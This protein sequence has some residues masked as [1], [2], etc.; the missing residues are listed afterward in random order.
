MATQLRTGFT[1]HTSA[2][3]RAIINSL[4]VESIQVAGF[5][6]KY[7]PRTSN[8]IDT[9]FEDAET[10]SFDDAY[11]IEM[12]FGANSLTGFGGDGDLI[13]QFGYEVRDTVQLVVS[14]SRFVSEIGTPASLERPREGDLIHL[15]F[16][17]QL[18]EI[19]FVEDQEPFF[20]LGY[21]YIYQLECSLFQYADEE[22][23]TGDVT[24]DS[25]ETALAYQINLT[26]NP[27]TGIFTVGTTVYQGEVGSET[28]KAEVVLWS[29]GTNTLRVMN[30]Q[31]AFKTTEVVKYDGSNYGTVTAIADQDTVT[32]QSAEFETLADSGIV[33]FTESNPFGDF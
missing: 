18:Y 27:F 15:P 8:N 28:A 9:I 10:S 14:L 30:I 29:S 12:Y 4:V 22:F 33:D 16:S 25:V 19:T 3:D 32:S 20:Q 23:D 6:V 5:E 7:L 13:T 31:G 1:H 17:K 11:A 26:V 2:N 21:G 24:I